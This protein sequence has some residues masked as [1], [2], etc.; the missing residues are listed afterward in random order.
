MALGQQLDARQVLW[1]EPHQHAFNEVA[2]RA[3]AHLE[4]L[5]RRHVRPTEP[6][7]QG[8]HRALPLLKGEQRSR[9]QQAVARVLR[10]AA[11]VAL[12]HGLRFSGFVALLH[13]HLVSLAKRSR[14]DP[15]RNT[16]HQP[17]TEP[18]P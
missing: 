9:V 1:R 11:R 4:Q 16:S 15:W 13:R 7:E 17:S 5:E 6:L 10:Q 8:Q 3:A 12:A 14:P 2:A 18:M